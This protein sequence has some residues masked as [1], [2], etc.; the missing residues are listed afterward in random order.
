M[1]AVFKKEF[2]SFFTGVI[3]C[4]FIAFLLCFTGIYITSINLRGGYASFEYVLSNIIIVF[5][6]IVPLL[7]M[8]SFAEE[9]HSR[10]D[11]LLYSLPVSVW[12]VVMG[13]YLAMLAVFAIPVGIM[14]LYPIILSAFGYM[15]YESAYLA[16]FG[17]FMLGAALIALCMF[18]SSLTE[19][20]VISAV[21]GFGA[22]LLMYM[23]QGLSTLI[24]SSSAGSLVC[25]CVTAL[26][27]SLVVYLFTK[28]YYVSIACFVLLCG[29]TVVFYLI[30]PDVFAGL[31]A[32]VLSYLAVFDRFVALTGGIFD[33]GAIIYLITFAV[34][35]VYLTVQSV[36]KRRWS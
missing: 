3:G 23:M 8:R 35:F 22:L 19:S 32:S 24:P 18:M 7:T 14:A 13:K 15:A 26:V 17:F 21:I 31:F 10:T 30:K 11:Q 2:K 36:E 20:Q 9:K 34:F 5:L 16:L 27:I 12:E 6:L 33:I 4:L 25:F 28:N 1:I 29:I